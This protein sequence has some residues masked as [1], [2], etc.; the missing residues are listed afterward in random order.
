MNTKLSTRFLRDMLRSLIT[1]F[2]DRE[3][4]HCLQSLISDLPSKRVEQ[5]GNV[6]RTE[7]HDKSKKQK[8]TAVALASRISASGRMKS[9]I[10]EL[11][12]QFDKKELLPSIGDVRSFLEL[13]GHRF[14]T[15]KQRADSF[16]AVL[17]ILQEL[18]E[19]E[20]EALSSGGAQ[21]GPTELGPLSDSIEF[22]GNSRREFSVSKKT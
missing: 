4:E 12:D 9:L 19:A 16:R 10:M 20:L 22:A 6:P 21:T 18:N 1:E 3:V 15:T 2:G 13:R 11:A 7:P 14:L 17:Q 5:G 8:T